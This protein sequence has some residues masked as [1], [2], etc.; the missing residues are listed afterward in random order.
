MR[1]DRMEDLF[2]EHKAV[3]LSRRPVVNERWEQGPSGWKREAE[4]EC[5]Q[6]E[7]DYLEPDWTEEDQRDRR[8]I[9]RFKTVEQALRKPNKNAGFPAR[10]GLDNLGQFKP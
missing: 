1:D 6:H 8:S 5:A 3:R 2:N 7:P 9:C 10:D 4:L